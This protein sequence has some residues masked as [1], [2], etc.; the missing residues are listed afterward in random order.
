MLLSIIAL[1]YEIFNKLRVCQLDGDAT[2]AVYR[3]LWT[4]ELHQKEAQK[5]KE[6]EKSKLKAEEN[7]PEF[8]P[9]TFQN[10]PLV[11]STLP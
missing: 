6:S 1:T 11:S 4:K 9:L 7:V 2:A 10:A 5:R 3:I 8:V